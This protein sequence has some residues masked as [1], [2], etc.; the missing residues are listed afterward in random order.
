MKLR[1]IGLAGVMSVAGLG[2]IGAGAHASFTTQTTSKQTISTGK[3]SVVLSVT[4]DPA[5]TGNGTP[6]LTLG[7][8]VSAGSSFMTAPELITI[9]NNGTVP[10]TEVALQLSDTNNNA[11]LKTELWTCLYSDGSSGGGVFFN[12]PLTTVEGYGQAAIGH[13]TL[14]PGATDSY[15]VVYYA[16]PTENTGCGTAY[17]GWQNIPY[18]GYPG[19]YYHAIAYAGAAPTLGAN[20]AAL[21]LTNGAENATITPMVTVSYT[22]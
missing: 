1:T 21:A 9:T 20:S 10:A 6:N 2:L 15:T 3:L 7:P 16:G 14:A 12:E 19:A 18:G 13:L 22:G 8:L 5:A 11:T 4:G 17:T